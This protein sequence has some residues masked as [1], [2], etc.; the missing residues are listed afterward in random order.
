MIKPIF[1]SEFMQSLFGERLV[2]SKG[3]SGTSNYDPLMEITLQDGGK[4]DS[5]YQWE[6]IDGSLRIL[7]ATG[8]LVFVF[9]GLDTKNGIVRITGQNTQI[10]DTRG[11]STAIMHIKKNLDIKRLGIRISSHIDYLSEAVPPLLTSLK[12]AGFDMNNVCVVVGGMKEPIAD[13]TDTDGVLFL[14]TDKNVHG[15]TGLSVQVDMDVDYWLLLHDTCKV[16]P[17]FMAKIA[18]IDVG[19]NQDIIAFTPWENH[20]EIGI[21]SSEY[22]DR[23]RLPSISIMQL[24][25]SIVTEANVVTNLGSGM[26]SRGIRDVY[27]NG[28]KR[29]A[30]SISRVGITKFRGTKM[31]GGR[32]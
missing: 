28:S 5:G 18:E 10:A 20:L 14:Y 7:E 11:W 27:G 30:L 15:F 1:S 31:G 32:P 2:I 22:L 24:M 19:L 13:V 25:P 17:D 6:I 29:E 12:A 3:V 9:D 21:Y 8:K 26:K 23:Q 4:T 16:D